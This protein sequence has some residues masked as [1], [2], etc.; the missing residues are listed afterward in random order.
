MESGDLQ[1]LKRDLNYSAFSVLLANEGERESSNNG[2]QLATEFLSGSCD[3]L[4][5]LLG[6]NE[7]S[8]TLLQS[9][10]VDGVVDDFFTE[11]LWNGKPVIKCEDIPKNSIVVNCSMSISPITAGRRL[12]KLD[13]RG[14]ISYAD[15][16]RLR[17]DLIL[18]PEFVVE[19]RKDVAENEM[20]WSSL[21]GKLV[22]KQSITVFNDLVRYR[23]SADPVYMAN[24]STRFSD[25]YFEDFLTLNNEVFV[26]AGGFDG[27]TTEEFCKR[28]P[29]YKKVI[30]FEPS[31]INMIKA[32]I[33]LAKHRDIEF[34]PQGI[35]DV[36]GSLSFNS[37]AGSA[38]SFSSEGSC[39]IEV[40]TLDSTVNEKV[41]FIKMDLEGWELKAL[42]GCRRHILEDHPKLAIS[43]Y[44]NASDFWR[45][46]ELI[47]SMR[48]DY[49][50]YIRHY[51]EGWS[52][53]IMFFVPKKEVILNEI[54][55]R[56]Y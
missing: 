50:I 30:L 41:T 19:M 7:H 18:A 40:T 53:T 9:I 3:G 15:L 27:D 42:A 28:Y 25:Q 13:L 23:L 29:T 45:I 39:S 31:D 32:K 47:L 22:D 43:V 36:C 17:P 54:G 56:Y 26:D 38:S 11:P 5:L 12:Q 24:Y 51:T 48:E 14:C 33:R 20:H 49:E 21:M 16:H 4:R 35:S 46:P 2:K 52:E 34:I 37:E 6:R 8:A 10:E 1:N 44:H 55:A